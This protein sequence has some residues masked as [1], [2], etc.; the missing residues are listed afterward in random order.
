MVVR[1]VSRID[2]EIADMDAIA[3]RRALRVDRDFGA[4][5]ARLSCADFGGDAP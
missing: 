1:P 3:G 5:S 2:L 4:R